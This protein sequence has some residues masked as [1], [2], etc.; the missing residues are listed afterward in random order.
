MRAFTFRLCS[1]RKDVYYTP[2]AFAKF[3]DG[4]NYIFDVKYHTFF[5]EIAVGFFHSE[6]SFTNSCKMHCIKCLEELIPDE[7]TINGVCE[8]WQLEE[9]QPDLNPRKKHTLRVMFRILRI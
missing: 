8:Y 1:N 9:H 5:E 2:D 4:K 6:K 7:E 3:R